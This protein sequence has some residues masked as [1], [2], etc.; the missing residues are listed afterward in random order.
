[1][2]SIPLVRRNA[3]GGEVSGDWTRKPLAAGMLPLDMPAKANPAPCRSA[4]TL[5]DGNGGEVRSACLE[6]TGWETICRSRCPDRAT[7]RL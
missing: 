4:G 7:L 6:A 5:T 3:F 1:M 2:K